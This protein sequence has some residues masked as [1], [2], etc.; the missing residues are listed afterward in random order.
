MVQSPLSR[1]TWELRSHACL[2]PDGSTENFELVQLCSR[3]CHGNRA[4][5]SLLK[6]EEKQYFLNNSDVFGLHAKKHLKLKA[7]HRFNKFISREFKTGLSNPGNRGPL[8]CMMCSPDY[9]LWPLGCL[10]SPW[11]V[12]FKITL[13]LNSLFSHIDCPW[14]QE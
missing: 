6:D 4:G 11:T 5:K 1:T 10:D 13:D 3:F 2:T 12:F 9:D 8:P 7:S 14:T